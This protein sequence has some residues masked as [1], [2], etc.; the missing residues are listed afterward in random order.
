MIDDV[1]RYV[2][3]THREHVGDDLFIEVDP[4]TKV[5]NGGLYT[6][7]YGIPIKFAICDRYTLRM[8]RTKK[9][10]RVY[11]WVKE[12]EVLWERRFNV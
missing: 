12:R 3:E 1:V 4:C 8:C 9:K 11:K 10:H 7:L 6:S 2:A 5:F